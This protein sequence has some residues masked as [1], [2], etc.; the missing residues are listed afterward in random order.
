MLPVAADYEAHTALPT[1]TRPA[2]RGIVFFPGST[3]GNFHPPEAVKFLQHMQTV[4]GPNAEILIGVDLKK[5]VGLLHRAYNDCDGVTAAFNLNI[6]TH[7]NREADANFD[8]SRFEHEAFYNEE[9]GR[10]EM[11]LVSL[12]R[13]PVD[14]AGNTICIEAGERIWTESSYKYSLDE[15]DQLAQQ[16]GLAVSKVW[17]DQNNLFSLQHLVPQQ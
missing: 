17:T 10:I 13:H 7:L 9:A 16:A 1:P 15:F 2:S 11:H 12:E 6:L 4:C 3:I 14:I 5:D 8:L